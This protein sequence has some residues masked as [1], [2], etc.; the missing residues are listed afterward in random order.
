MVMPKLLLTMML[1]MP[2]ILLTMILDPQTPKH[3]HIHLETAIM[4]PVLMMMMPPPKDSASPESLIDSKL[5][6]KIEPNSMIKKNLKT[7]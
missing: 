7:H 1:L 6:R 4:P 3:A 5:K 2:L